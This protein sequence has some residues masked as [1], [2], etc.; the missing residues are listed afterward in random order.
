MS[1]LGTFEINPPCPSPASDPSQPFVVK[2]S[3]E[4][5]FW[6]LARYYYAT[7]LQLTRR[8]HAPSSLAWCQKQLK[9]LVEKRYVKRKQI[10]CQ[11]VI[12]SGPHVYMLAAK[13]RNHLRRKEYDVPP[14]P[15]SEALERESDWEHTLYIT[16]ILVA[17]DKLAEHAPDIEI[18]EVLHDRPLKRQPLAGLYG[19]FAPDTQYR[20]RLR[21]HERAR[22]MLIEADRG[23]INNQT[24]LRT[25]FDK[26]ASWLSG[27]LYL[28]DVPP[29]RICFLT[30][31]GP[32][33]VRQLVRE[34]QQVL[35]W[36]W[37]DTLWQHFFFTSFNPFSPETSGPT[38]LGYDDRWYLPF[39]PQ[40]VPLFVRST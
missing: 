22:T 26:L 35:R 3:H 37:N 24:K 30:S 25:K 4:K 20:I 19:E 15:P 21:G 6:S 16:D 34:C 7:A 14:Y 33:R 40:P 32:N 39:T 17:F 36:H 12:G 10:A 13:A 8:W 27:I 9:L 38:S 29:P 5:Y 18:E 31:A 28:Q 1:L 23:T 2:L 11:A